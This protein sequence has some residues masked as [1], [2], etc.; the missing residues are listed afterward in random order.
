MSL[1][2]RMAPAVW[3]FVL[4][5]LAV[6]ALP[7]AGAGAQGAMPYELWVVDQGNAEGGGNKVYVYRG[8]QLG[9][10]ALTGDAE[11]IDLQAGATGV[12]DGPG[13]RPHLLLFNTR[14]THGVLAAVA[15]G[16]VLF[17]RASDRKVTGSVDVGDQA[18]GAVPSD[19][20]RIVLVANQN[21][22]KLARIR[23]DYAAE[24]YVHEA[25]ADLDLG[26]LED[27]EH[28]D[29]APICPV[30]F[31]DGG[32]KAYVTVRGG[33][34]Y[35]VDTGATPMRV[36]RQYGRSQVAPAGCGGV[37]SGNKVYVELGA[38]RRSSDLYVFDARTDDLIK[39]LPLTPYGTD[40]HGLALVG[41]GRHLWFA[42]RGNGDNV[43][44]IDTARDEVVNV[45]S[46][47]GAAPDL[48]D[49]A[50]GALGRSR[51][52]PASTVMCLAPGGTRAFV[53]MRPPNNLTGGPTG[54]G[55]GSGIAVM[56]IAENGRSGTRLFFFPIGNEASDT[57]GLAVRLTTLRPVGLPEDRR[58]ARGRRHRRRGT[59]VGGRL[60]PAGTGEDRT[61]AVPGAAARCAVRCAAGL[62]R[63]S[64]SCRRRSTSPAWSAP[65]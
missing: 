55:E 46:D 29:N 32:R 10:A 54:S 9:G 42:N 41:G 3:G 57:H 50:P 22:K 39:H 51:C 19:D 63:R 8:Q 12:G 52:E 48:I 40:G 38:A 26:A 34:M 65:S 5:V 53:T 61:V 44:V 47:V 28:P 14:H 35:I 43:V 24:R 33:G 27:A 25:E 30:M 6:L 59:G 20:D 36:I 11:V 56:S 45:L 62:R 60:T 7:T 4:A 21:G 15:S 31:V 64:R 37:V 2:P 16:H 13:V 17:I 49:V 58:G 23:T 18:H 1:V